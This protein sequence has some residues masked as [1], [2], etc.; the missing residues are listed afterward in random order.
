LGILIYELFVG[1]PPFY[2]PEEEKTF[3]CITYVEDIV[4][5][6]KPFIPKHAKN[7]IKKLL[8]KN[9]KKRLGFKDGINEIF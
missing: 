8:N 7:I 1:L 2:Q 4:F 3:S 5:P 9:P 6:K